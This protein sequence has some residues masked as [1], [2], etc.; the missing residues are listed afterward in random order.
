MAASCTSGDILFVYY[1]GHG[2]KV[3]DLDK[4]EVDGFDEAFCLRS[5]G[6]KYEFLTDD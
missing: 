2:T 1:S 6:G 5:K 3:P 4:D